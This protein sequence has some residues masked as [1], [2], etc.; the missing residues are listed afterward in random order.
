MTALFFAALIGGI[1]RRD[2]GRVNVN[3]F[4]LVTFGNQ[5]QLVQG[6]NLLDVVSLNNYD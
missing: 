2:N 4:G 6:N 5:L 1:E 3:A